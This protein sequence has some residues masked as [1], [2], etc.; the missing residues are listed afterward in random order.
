MTL[1]SLERIGKALAAAAGFHTGGN[2]GANGGGGG[3]GGGANGGGD[4]NGAANGS[5]SAGSR[6]GGDG[7]TDRLVEPGLLLQQTHILLVGS[8]RR[9]L[10]A[11]DVAGNYL[12]VFAQIPVL[13][14]PTGFTLAHGMLYF[15]GYVRNDRAV[16]SM[17]RAR[18]SC[19]SCYCCRCC[20][21]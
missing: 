18:I 3:G 2:N 17:Q 8:H 7:S 19:R 16:I 13:K 20:C 11:F 14:H 12:G 9:T 5:S 6:A 1:P 15:A 21:C 10:R 4:G